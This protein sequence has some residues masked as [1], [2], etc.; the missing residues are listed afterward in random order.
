MNPLP[1]QITLVQFA[2][3]VSDSGQLP[4]REILW[5][6][7][8]VGQIV[9]FYLF[10]ALSMLV[11][12]WGIWCRVRLWLKGRRD[13][14]RL[15]RPAARFK[16]IWDYVLKQRGVRRKTR[17]STFHSLIFY[18]FLV[19]LF[20]TTM[21]FIDNDLGWKIY[22]GN[23]YL[24]VTVL[25]DL[26]G[27]GLLLGLL[28]AAQIRYLEHNDRLHST[29]A[30][31]WAIN[32]LC[33]LV[34]QGYLLEA[35]RIYVTA[36]PWRYYSPVG[37]ALSLA[38]WSISPLTAQVLHWMTWWFHS[39]TVFAFIALLPYSKLFHIIASSANLYFRQIDRPK[40]ALAWPGDLEKL[41]EAA[42]ETE[43]GDFSLGIS[44]IE[45]LSWKQRL[46]LDA[47]TSCG[48]CQE[49]C[50]AYNSGKVL[51][52]KW[53]I[54]DSRNHL[55][56]LHTQN[57]LAGSAAAA[58]PSASLTAALDAVDRRLLNDYLLTPVPL[59]K[60]GPGGIRRADNPLVDAAATGIG[61]RINAPIAGEVM[62]EDVFWSCTS[63]RACME[64]CPVGIEHV[65]Y[66]MD[67]RR[68]LTLIQGSLPQEAQSSLKAIETRG[69]PFGP[70]EERADWAEGHNVPLL[71]PGDAVD[72]LYWVGCVS[73][74][75]KRKQKIARSMAKILNASGLSWGIL[76]NRERCS[77][78]PARRLGDENLFQGAAKCN[79]ETLRSVKFKTIV[80]NCPHCFNSLK[81]EYPQIGPIAEG[82]IRVLHHTQLISELIGQGRLKVKQGVDAQITFHD[83]CYLARY[84]DTTEEPREILVQLA[85]KKPVEMEQNG[86]LG[87]CCGAGGGHFWMDLKVGERI[88]KI[89]T[90]QALDSGSQI[91]ATACPFCLQM[92]EDGS[93]ML[94]AEEKIAVRDI[95]ELVA[96]NLTS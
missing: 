65:D 30:D 77:G 28:Y 87:L 25:S 68:N 66:I 46:D 36:D 86:K 40:G 93:K 88:N 51:S 53:L 16:V 60:Q 89:R 69:N 31:R 42:A 75:D 1:N 38:F 33:L 76:G 8:G 56:S 32:L 18:G 44:T 13:D 43:S 83:P 90:Q 72:V 2:A 14:N 80:A 82:E 5:N 95:S 39:L 27:L 48:R 67:V 20:T 54:L 29:P 74:Y 49:V 11:F 26:F 47:C 63:C 23:F 55:F 57:I 52:P 94:N 73:A 45:D 10:F 4:S 35:M 70:G 37:W 64:V 6:I 17:V 78:D 9:L 7:N 59:G 34:V 85:R 71:K 15:N 24:A 21:V 91:V 19:L 12:V 50:P 22:R 58:Q 41:L 61:G 96:E 3:I 81:N 79:V 84:N 62:E 92:I